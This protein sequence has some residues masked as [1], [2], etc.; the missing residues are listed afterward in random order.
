MAQSSYNIKDVYNDIFKINDY[1]YEGEKGQL[2]LDET[3]GSF[4][5]YCHYGSSSGNDKCQNNYFKIASSSVIHLLK[6]SKKYGLEY[7]KLAEYTILWLSY[8]LN[9][10]KTD[11]GMD[12]N[13]FYTS[14][15]VNN[16]SYN[17]KINGDGSTYKDIINKKINLLNIKEISK[18]NDPFGMLLSLYYLVHLKKLDC[19]KCLQ[20]ANEFVKN[21]ETLNNDSN[22]IKDSP[23]SQ[24]LS[25]LSN[26]YKN[27]IK[28]YHNKD[29]SCDFPPLLDLNPKKISV[30]KSGKDGEQISLQPPE[31]TS[32]SSSILNTVIPGLSTFAIPLFLGVAYKVNNNKL[33]II[34]FKLYFCDPLYGFIK[35]YI[36]DYHFYISIH[37]L[38]LINYFKDNI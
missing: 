7:D 30:E 10:K 23:F 21:F 36:Y 5:K 15:I 22:N 37:Y 27:F 1:F 26:D 35:K 25:T 17:E 2:I 33:K 38:E 32:S 6:D 3:H 8:K 11:C 29:K 4:D 24:I 28:I 12:L 19:E 31:I 16:N 34:I 14:Y 9:T 18:F 20:K 13:T